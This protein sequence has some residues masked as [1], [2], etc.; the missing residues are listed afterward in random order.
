[1]LDYLRRGYRLPDSTAPVA[2]LVVRH[3]L[4]PFSRRYFDLDDQRLFSYAR[5]WLEAART[6]VEGEIPAFCDA[7]LPEPGEAPGTAFRTLGSAFYA[8]RSSASSP[9]ASG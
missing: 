8:I 4:Q 1:M 3:P 2:Q 5:T 9:S 6:Q 7:E